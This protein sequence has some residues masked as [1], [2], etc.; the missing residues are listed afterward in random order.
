MFGDG[1]VVDY[2]QDGL[3]LFWVGDVPGVADHL[4]VDAARPQGLAQQLQQPVV[5]G[6]YPDVRMS[7]Y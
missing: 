6:G 7:L 2:P 3:D 5:V 1:V 4:A